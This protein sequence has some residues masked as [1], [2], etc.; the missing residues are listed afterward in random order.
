MQCQTFI[1]C[2]NEATT[3]IRNPVVGDVPCCQRC[4]D[5]MFCIALK[6]NNCQNPELIKLSDRKGK[7]A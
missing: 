1:L 3:T 6:L 7:L 2:S 4:K 5:K